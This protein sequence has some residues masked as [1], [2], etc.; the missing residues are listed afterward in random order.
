MNHFKL[1]KSNPVK[2]TLGVVFL[3]ALAA[4]G[5]NTVVSTMAPTTSGLL[6]NNY[7]YGAVVTLDSN[8]DGVCSSTE[9][10]VVTSLTGSY[11]FPGLGDHMVCSSGGYNVATQLPF[12]G[13]LKAPTRSKVMTPLTTLVV[14][15]LP[16]NTPSP[17]A[18]QIATATSNVE[19][20]LSLPAG[21]TALDPVASIATSPKIE[22]T[23]AAVQAMLST[24]SRSVAALAGVAAP[25]AASTSAQKATYEAAVNAVF[26]NAVKAVA[27][28]LKA[29]NVNVDLT[30][31]AASTA[32]TTFV[33]NSIVAAVTEVK[34]TVAS[35]SGTNTLSAALNAAA[36]TAAATI[37]NT[38][39][40]NAAATVAKNISTVVQSVA[41]TVVTSDLAA[42]KAAMT[43][44]ALLA[45]SNTTIVSFVET[46]KAKA[47][48][49]FVATA[50]AAPTQMAALAEAILPSASVVA[51][52]ATTVNAG[53][54]TTALTAAA[55]AAQTV[56]VNA[57]AITEIAAVVA[58]P[59]AAPVQV[60]L[61]T[62]TLPTVAPLPPPQT[63]SL[64][65]GAGV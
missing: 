56:V 11:S 2:F 49:L 57:T 17:T 46:I 1:V 15:S 16:A 23:N 33:Q 59:P 60:V 5:G 22:Q 47:P 36:P 45:Q 10:Q 50:T 61:T 30:S 44:A 48:E 26:S 3:A 21:S 64:T 4:C 63:I 19:T 32:N 51:N 52:V 35:N 8:D 41:Q 54:A 65:G 29:S 39:S 14:A 31:A 18:A 9:P 58:A 34:I 12:T 24:A 53:T 62:V 55:T 20:K 40:V 38:S 6:V 42:T 25:T 7:V 27:D 13:I 28:T 37:A 43:A